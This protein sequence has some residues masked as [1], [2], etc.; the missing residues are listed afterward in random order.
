MPEIR[1]HDGDIVFCETSY[2]F[3]LK[4]I[5]G[6]RNRVSVTF[7]VRA[8]AFFN[9]FLQTIINVFVLPAFRDLRL[10]VELDLIHQQTSEALGLRWTS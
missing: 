2:Q 5:A 3:M 8:A 6:G 4:V 10:I 9:R 1:S 7:L